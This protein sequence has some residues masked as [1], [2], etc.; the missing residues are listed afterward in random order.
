MVTYYKCPSC[1]KEVSEY[2]V[3]ENELIV[4]PFCI[5]TFYAHPYRVCDSREIKEEYLQGLS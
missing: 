5:T 1:G 2:N 4:C 3:N